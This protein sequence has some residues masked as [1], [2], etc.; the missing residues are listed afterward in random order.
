MPNCLRNTRLK[1]R[2]SGGYPT[3]SASRALVT[4]G[5]QS[6]SRRA[7]STRRLSM[8]WVSRVPVRRLNIR[9]R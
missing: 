2:P 5:S 9:L 1:Y 7:T 6:I 3:N 4:L 8:K